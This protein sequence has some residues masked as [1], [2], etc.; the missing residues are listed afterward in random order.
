MVRSRFLT[1]EHLI[2]A[3]KRGD[4]YASSGVTLSDVHFDS[5]S[6]TLSVD[7]LA[8]EAASYTTEFIATLGETSTSD[9]IGQTVAIV[10]GLA[11][12]YTMQGTELYVRAV[13][14]SSH[15][16][17]DPSF[18]GQLQQAWTQPVGWEPLAT[19]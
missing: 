9:R 4:F 8:D 18:T 14:T 17:V 7:I 5:R 3:M 11:P 2:R 15:P 19:D 12:R 10:E 1:P 6:R 16:A 13:V